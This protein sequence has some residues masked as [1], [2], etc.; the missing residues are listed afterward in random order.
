[1]K[2]EKM[3][4][5]ALN[6]DNTAKYAI[7][8]G[9]PDRCLKIAEHLD[10][11]KKLAQNREHTSYEGYLEGEKIL[12]TSTGMGGPSAAICM[13]ELVSIGVDTFIRVGTGA[14]TSDDVD[15]G[16]VVIPNGAVRMEG[17]GLHYLPIEFPA[18]P[19]FELIKH[20]ESAAVRCGFVPKIGVTITKDSFFTEKNPQDK[21]I[22]YELI[23]KWK[24]DLPRPRRRRDH[25]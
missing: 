22:G 19:D 8:P 7:V 12:V 16:D 2:S 1:M 14:S 15:R 3:L 18:V 25:R 20:L 17:T 9:N 11:Y 23:N 6:R 13:E 21:P 24:C 4:H 5:T 10:K